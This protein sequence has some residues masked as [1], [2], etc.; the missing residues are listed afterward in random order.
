[1]P[2]EHFPL[3]SF[4]PGNLNVQE[5]LD[6][7]IATLKM[8]A[9]SPSVLRS[10]SATGSGAAPGAWVRVPPVACSLV[11]SLLLLAP[12]WSG[13]A[14]DS[15]EGHRGLASVLWRVNSVGR[16]GRWGTPGWKDRPGSVKVEEPRVL[17]CT[18]PLQAAFTS[19][20]I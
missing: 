7:K 9:G 6:C 8:Q 4:A 1:M 11:C 15:L 17:G 19:W 10:P 16:A 20:G 14:W 12:L 2:G 5:F 13:V 18:L 3:G